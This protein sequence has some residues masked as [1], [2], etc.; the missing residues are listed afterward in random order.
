MQAPSGNI[1][2]VDDEPKILRF[3]AQ[4]LTGHGYRLHMAD[5]GIQALQ[6][7]DSI[8]T[9][10]LIDLVLLDIQ[11]PGGWDGIETCHRLKSRQD[12]RNI[13]V[14]FL[15]GKD[16]SETMVRAFDAGG[17]DYLLKPFDVKVLLARVR[18]HLELGRLSRS[19]EAALS[20][21][22]RELL[23]ANQKLRRLA[24]DISLVGEREKQRLA[25]ELHDSPMQKLALAQ[26]QITSAAR[27]RDVES[28]RMFET[29]L[30]LLRASL[31]ELRTLQ[32]DLSPPV[33]YQE[34]LVP[35]LRWLVTHMAQRFGLEMVF[36]ETGSVPALDREQ[37]L[38]A[39]Q[40]AREFVCNLVKHA[41]ATRGWLEVGGDANSVILS[42][43]DNGKGFDPEAV[44]SPSDSEDGVGLFNT[45]ERL[46]LWGGRLSIESNGSGTR[47]SAQI[48][49]HYRERA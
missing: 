1:L 3:L 34:G 22:T 18:T 48:P 26:V 29:G 39:F 13:P 12:A 4:V 21:R 16:D 15:T 8:S 31:Q 14:I 47:V 24:R 9:D 25:R 11:M 35:A 33:L 20:E 40:C 7:L 37:A 28:N 44:A 43:R 10:S 2:V 45:R 49:L 17:A 5:N 46:S 42:V 41:E 36:T 19:L 30:E 23:E 6:V 32:F 38:L 27:S